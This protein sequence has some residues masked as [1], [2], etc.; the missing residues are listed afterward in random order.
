MAVKRLTTENRE[1]NF[2]TTNTL[3]MKKQILKDA[4]FIALFYGITALGA[5]AVYSFTIQTAQP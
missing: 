5:F 3:N 4:L 2:F 1:T